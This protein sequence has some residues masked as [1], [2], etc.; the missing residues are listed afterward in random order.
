M[1][2]FNFAQL[3]DGKMFTVVFEKADGSIRVMNGRTGV[4]KHLA[5]G[6]STVAGKKDLFAGVFDVH[7]KG[8]R[9]FNI[10]RVLEVRHHGKVD[11][12]HEDHKAFLVQKLEEE[13]ARL[14]SA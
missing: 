10:G 6:K 1:S 5:G 3:R 8:Y 13:L 9:C 2:N 4:V 7:A 14:K 11:K 12:I